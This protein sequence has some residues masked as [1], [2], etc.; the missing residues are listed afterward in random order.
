[1]S[2]LDFWGSLAGDGVGDD[3]HLL[4]MGVWE[5]GGVGLRGGEGDIELGNQ[6]LFSLEGDLVEAPPEPG[7]GGFGLEGGEAEVFAFDVVEVEDEL[8]G[9]GTE[10]GGVGGGPEVFAPG[11]VVVLAGEEV[12]DGFVLAGEAVDQ[13][14]DAAEAAE[15]V[16]DQAGSEGFGVEGEVDDL[17]ASDHSRWILCER[18]GIA[19]EAEVDGVELEMGLEE[20]QDARGTKGTAASDGVGG[21]GEEDEGFSF[22]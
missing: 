15:E 9:V 2:G 14:G 6:V 3:G 4:R 13:G 16:A 12:A 21:F 10:E 20:F 19:G 1:M 17:P 18:V 7:F 8:F 5:P 22:S 11:E